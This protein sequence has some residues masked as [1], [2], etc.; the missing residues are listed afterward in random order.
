MASRLMEV[1]LPLYTA[2]MRPH[3]EYCVEMYSSQYRRNM[4]PI[5]HIQRKA[6]KMTQGM[7]N[8]S[9][10]DRQRELGL[11]SLEKRGLQ[12][13]PRAAFQHLKGGCKKEGNRLFS[14]VCCDRTR[15]NGFKQKEGRFRLDIRQK[16]FFTMKVVRHRNR[17][18]R[19]MVDVLSWEM[20]RVRLDGDLRNLI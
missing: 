8:L 9:Y 10:K 4:D 15:G 5:E 20:L 12:G 6:T 1:I 3:L 2:L 16:G 7:E 19:D 17:L 18:P 14:R 11:Y 13:D